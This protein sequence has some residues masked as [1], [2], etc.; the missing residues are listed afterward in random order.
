MREQKPPIGE[1]QRITV[2]REGE[3][4]AYEDRE[5]ATVLYHRRDDGW[6]VSTPDDDGYWRFARPEARDRDVRQLIN[7]KWCLLYGDPDPWDDR[8]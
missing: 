1:T 6:Y 2:T 8:S 5:E 4:E 7:K 3:T